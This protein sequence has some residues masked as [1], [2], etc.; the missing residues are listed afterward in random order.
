[1]IEIIPFDEGNI[2]GFKLAGKIDDQSYH[3]AVNAINAALENNNKIRI[4]AEV[5][6]IGGMSLDAF[7]DNIKTKFG[8]FRELDRFEKEAV[9]SDKKWI[10]S[11]VG[12]SDA[13]FRS[14]E[15]RHFSFEETEEALDWVKS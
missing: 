13:I 11:L 12:I 7:F 14:V 6:S 15:V 2:V 4:Y 5:V 1:M 10:E 3:N 9:V 8:Y